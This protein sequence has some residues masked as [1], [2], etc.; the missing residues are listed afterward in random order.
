VKE[1]NNFI[2]SS[3]NLKKNQRNDF[4]K[5]IGE[6]C[7]KVKTRQD[8]SKNALG[9]SSEEKR[10]A[11]EKIVNEAL[12]LEQT[13]AGIEESIRK[14]DEAQK[15]WHGKKDADHGGSFDNDGLT[16]DDRDKVRELLKKSKDEVF[17]RR[18][19]LRQ[20]NF[21]KIATRI[22]EISDKVFYKNPREAFN[23]IKKLRTE[24]RNV[25]L[26][27]DHVKEIDD[28]INKL[29]NKA[30]E[31]LNERREEDTL[32]RIS[33]LEN[34]INKNHQFIKRLQ[35]EI[36]DLKIKWADVQNDMFRNRVNEWIDEKTAKIAQVTEE[37]KG[38]QEKINFLKM[39]AE[40]F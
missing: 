2:F 9:K 5:R 31:K 30:G 11:I 10:L 14:M 12:A 34:L 1:L 24:M 20:K 22:K 18:R 26:D 21:E 25:P 8:E 37:I 7:V 13:A 16:R 39:Q 23:Q 29:W 38:L 19:N 32:K 28:V 27:R 35:K 4:K 6:L 40:R 17:G 36:D 15:L 3:P 33:G